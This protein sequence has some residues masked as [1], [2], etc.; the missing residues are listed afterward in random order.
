VQA[1]IPARLRLLGFAEILKSS[2]KNAE[3]A[4]SGLA[5]NDVIFTME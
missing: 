4:G 2:R 3:K 5:D 1:E